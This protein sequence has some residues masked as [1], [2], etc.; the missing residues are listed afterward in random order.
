MKMS[1]PNRPPTSLDDAMNDSR[2]QVR[3]GFCTT[4]LGSMKEQVA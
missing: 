1:K 2:R 4:D 3:G